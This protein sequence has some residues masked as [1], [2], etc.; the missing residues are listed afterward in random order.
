MRVVHVTPYFA[1]AFCYGGPPRSVSALCRALQRQGV[2]VEVVTTTANGKGELR[3]SGPGGDQYEGVRVHYLPRA[4]PRRCFGAR[5]LGRVLS[6]ALERCD[7][8]HV[9][10]LWNIPAAVAAHMARQRGVPYVVST[11]G[12]MEGPARARHPWRKRLAY[13]LL[14]RRNLAGACLLHATSAAEAATLRRLGLGVKIVA[15]PNGV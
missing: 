2:D 11:R 7:V 10:G 15:V 3:A 1:P 9:H 14:E 5:R 8:L 6:S 13:F 12:M 4:F